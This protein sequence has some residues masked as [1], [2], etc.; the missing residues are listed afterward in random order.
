MS[1]KEIGKQI[2]RDG[3]DFSPNQVQDGHT[4]NLQKAV[5]NPIFERD[6]PQNLEALR[7]QELIE[8]N[9]RMIA[10]LQEQAGRIASFA[11]ESAMNLPREHQMQLAANIS[12]LAG[13]PHDLV[14]NEFLSRF[15]KFSD[16]RPV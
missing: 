10:Q 14:H 6:L 13:S 7:Q 2:H 11:M 8:K 1:E 15:S 3:V 12:E 9:A 4:E 16:S 5:Y